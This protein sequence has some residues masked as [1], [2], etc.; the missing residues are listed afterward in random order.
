MKLHHVGIVVDSIARHAVHYRQYLGMEACS[1]VV[2]DP[3]QKVRV[4]FWALPGQTPVELIEPVGEDSPVQSALR[5]GGGLNHLGFEVEDID[6]A[7][8]SAVDQG[9]ICA[10]PMMS[11]AA[12]DGRRIAF[13]FL[14]HVGLVEYIEMAGAHV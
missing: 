5:K 8:R 1:P 14:R 7:V 6:R 12:F 11:A 4:Q 3:N 2:E 9:G 10:R 13:V